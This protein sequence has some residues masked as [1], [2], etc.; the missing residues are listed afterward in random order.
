MSNLAILS[1]DIGI[2]LEIRN[3]NLE[4]L[5]MGILEWFKKLFGGEEERE[6]AQ[7]QESSPES[8][9]R[10]STPEQPDSSSEQGETSSEEQPRQE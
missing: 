5:S 8:Q 6:E 4:I 3:Y 9:P 10:E 7:G 1:L 2:L